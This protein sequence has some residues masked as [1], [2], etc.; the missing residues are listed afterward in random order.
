[1][2]EV[3]ETKSLSNYLVRHLT[4]RQIQVFEAVT[5]YKSFTKAAEALHLTQP[6]VSIQI[7]SFQESLN[8][9][10]YEQLGRHFYLTELGEQ[11]AIACR[12]I[13]NTLANL[14]IKLDDFNGMRKG[15]LRVSAVT[16]A[17]YFL[18]LAIGQFAKQYPDI[19]LLFT[20]CNRDA[21]LQR[22]DTNLDD[23]YIMGQK[24][25]STLD[26]VVIPFTPNPLV[27]IAHSNHPLC[28]QAKIPL[29]VIAKEPI[30]M[31]EQG[32]GTRSAVEDKF[33]SVGLTLNERL[34]LESTETIKQAVLGE[35][36]VAVVPLHSVQLDGYKGPISIL[37]VEGFPLEKEL[38][39]VYPN[40]KTL[41]VIANEF[42]NFLLENGADCFQTH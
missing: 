3:M 40:G 33:K 21:L 22:I 1:M 39:L 30:L 28:H 38:N 35:L 9:V 16:S 5:R 15:R 19:E 8:V 29:D 32:S 6:T 42:L 27:F 25:P 24:P 7:K 20:I 2:K 14:E 31:R 18:P 13:L 23:L 10:L 17:K 34:T 11:V 4:L 36:G 37:D 12:E 26:A 41:S